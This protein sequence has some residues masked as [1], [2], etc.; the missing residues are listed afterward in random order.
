ME[1]PVL[2]AKK[3][4]HGS[5]ADVYGLP[6][7]Q[8]GLQRLAEIVLQSFGRRHPRLDLDESSDFLKRDLGFLDGR[9]PYREDE[10]FR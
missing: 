2:V 5:A 6:F 1:S 4:R 10:R 8:L 9:T 3:D 7:A